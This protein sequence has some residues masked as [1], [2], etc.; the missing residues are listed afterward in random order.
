MVI[1]LVSY[2]FRPYEKSRWSLIYSFM[3]ISNEWKNIT[4]K[5]TVA[6]QKIN[7]ER[8]REFFSRFSISHQA[9]TTKITI[10]LQIHIGL[11]TAALP[12]MN[13]IRRYEK[14]ITWTTHYQLS[15]KPIS[16]YNEND[17]ISWRWRYLGNGLIL[18][19]KEI[20]GKK[21]VYSKINSCP[22]VFHRVYT[23]IL[24]FGGLRIR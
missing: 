23:G 19:Q 4:Y 6:R 13:H 8:T 7:T 3:Y 16:P 14:N 20:L 2:V 24:C 9:Y 22:R 18:E 21:R 17:L 15:T 12:R 10:F 5:F 11:I 1:E